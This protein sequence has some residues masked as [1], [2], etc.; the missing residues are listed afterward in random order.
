MN[1]RSFIWKAL[2]GLAAIPVIGKL[3]QGRPEID[4]GK[5]VSSPQDFKLQ[6]YRYDAASAWRFRILSEVRTYGESNLSTE[7]SVVAFGDWDYEQIDE[8]YRHHG[9]CVY[10]RADARI[11]IFRMTESELVARGIVGTSPALV[12]PRR[13]VTIQNKF[14]SLG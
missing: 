9:L 8:W 12:F 2:A 14:A 6:V 1:R 11:I 13:Q 5:F 10:A 7:E 3:V 4:G